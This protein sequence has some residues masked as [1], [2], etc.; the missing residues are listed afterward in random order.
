MSHT[1]GLTGGI[2]CGKST[3]ASFIE[4]AGVP[5]IDLDS[6][7]REVVVPGS[8]CLVRIVEVFGPE[9]VQADGSL[10]RKKLGDLVFNGH[11]EKCRLEAIMDQY[12]H[13]RLD[14][15]IAEK[16]SA[17]LVG[18][19][20]AILIERG[21]SERFRPLV[22]VNTTPEV[23]LQRLMARNG[24]SQAEA[25]ARIQSQ[26]PMSEKIKYA[27]FI[28]DTTCDL[29]QLASR[30]SELVDALRKTVYC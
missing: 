8:P 5:V 12:I 19:D 22:V 4:K 21:M 11:A 7:A 18:V 25:M 24:L 14:E 1:F 28:L 10:D 9:Y 6:V 29:D 16:S 2:A 13:A 23:Q 20:G 15:R 17:P 26:M 3:V 27:D 30:V